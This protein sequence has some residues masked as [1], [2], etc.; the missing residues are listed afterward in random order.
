M[1]EK[2]KT[3]SVWTLLLGYLVAV[4]WIVGGETANVRVD[5]ISV[6]ISDNTNNK[7][8]AFMFC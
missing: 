6:S 1:K 3:A 8:N 7:F 2:L 4:L 5:A